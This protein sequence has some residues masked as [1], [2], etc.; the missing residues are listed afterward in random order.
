[1]F[2]I[3]L[4]RGRFS[5]VLEI[6]RRLGNAQIK[7]GISLDLHYVEHYVLEIRL[8]LGNAQ[9]KFGISLDLH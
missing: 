2:S 5:T 4:S 9:I 8:R 1:M 3:F 6:R 7:F